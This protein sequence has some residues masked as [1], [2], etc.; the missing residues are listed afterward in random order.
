MLVYYCPYVAMNYF[1]FSRLFAE[2]SARYTQTATPRTGLVVVQLNRTAIG[3]SAT[4][5]PVHVS[6]RR[7]IA[8]FGAGI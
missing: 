7:R 8:Q 4:P 6:R 5:T 2:P 1:C 3:F